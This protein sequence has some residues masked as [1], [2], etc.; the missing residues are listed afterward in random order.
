MVCSP[1]S[2]EKRNLKVEKQL[3]DV[4]KKGGVEEG[5]VNVLIVEEDIKD[6]EGWHDDKAI[7]DKNAIGVVVVFLMF[8]YNVL[9]VAICTDRRLEERYRDGLKASISVIMTS[10]IKE[11]GDDDIKEAVYVMLLI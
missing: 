2:L 11:A 7:V 10:A 3:F 9:V 5:I 1:T 4:D 8:P 6:D